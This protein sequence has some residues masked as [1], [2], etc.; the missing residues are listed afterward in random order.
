MLNFIKIKNYALIES[1]E[2]EFAPGFN[3][4]TGE[5]GAGKSIL[6]GAIDLLLG[7]RS[8]RGAIRNG[9]TKAEV[10]G[11]FNVPP[12][13]VQ[14][15]NSILL[16]ADIPFDPES[17]ELYFRRVVTSSST[18]NYINDTPVSAK[19][20]ADTGSLLIDRHRAGEQLSL[21]Q[22]SRQ[23]E[24]L[25]RYGDLLEKRAACVAAA[26]AVSELEQEI[27]L[28]EAT[29]P[30]ESEADRLSLIVEEIERVNPAPGEDE[31]LAA[32][33]SL[34]ANSQQILSA[35]GELSARLYESENSIADQL[36]VVCRQL[37][38]LERI[39]EKSIS[40]LVS[41]CVEIQ[42]LTS[43][44]AREITSLADHI[45]LDP[46]EFAAL[47]TRMAELHTLKRRYAPSIELLLETLE[48]ARCRLDDFKRAA[49]KRE[50]FIQRRKNLLSQ[51]DKICQ[52][53]SLLRKNA[54]DSLANELIKRLDMIGFK[55]ARIVPEFSKIDNSPSGCDHFELNFSA[56]PGE[57]L[58]PLRKIASSGE[59]SRIMLAFKVVL[60]DS[61]AIPTVIFDE[62][63]MNIG[64]ETAGK[65]GEALKILSKKRQ[66]ISISHLPQVASQAD[67]H[68]LVKK[69][70]SDGRTFS[71]VEELHD[72]SPE[73][74]R[75]LS[76][77]LM[78]T[79]KV[80][81]N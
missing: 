46:E 55:H 23:L 21:L 32:R 72:T 60:A 57:A 26:K 35:A 27:K 34:A 22:T 30:D 53:L 44:L 18:R 17:R 5:S 10:S 78:C 19:L 63:D 37:S 20:L 33:H 9:C 49:V 66:I 79:P 39:D 2:L 29:L 1:S 50:E 14:E 62:I 4:F 24:L 68:F 41:K 59:L 52:E 75:M 43:D 54:A 51:Q 42:E 7:G 12:Y 76:P 80:G 15:I 28:F 31:E 61:D 47:E 58:R 74:A 13:L 77:L 71:T 3:V 64:G 11:S 40:P 73:L 67:R 36:G 56:N 25:D 65:V 45:E 16:S 70:V 81:H 38:D 48:H 6:L 8:D 69:F